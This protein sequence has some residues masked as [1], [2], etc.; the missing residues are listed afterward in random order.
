MLDIATVAAL[1]FVP[2]M[3]TCRWRVS[4]GNGSLP[5]CREHLGHRLT[6]MNGNGLFDITTASRLVMQK[7][8]KRLG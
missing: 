4:S 2:A 3:N 5:V 8:Y 7:H 6:S 1:L